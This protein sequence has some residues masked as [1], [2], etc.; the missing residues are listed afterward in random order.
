LAPTPG[1]GAGD[2][3][4]G[5][6]A[7]LRP[8]CRCGTELPGGRGG[9]RDFH[10]H[11]HEPAVLCPTE[12]AGVPGAARQAMKRVNAEML[13]AYLDGELDAVARARVEAWLADHPVAAAALEQRRR[14]NELWEATV[15]PVPVEARWTAVRARI[16][17]AMPARPMQRSNQRLVLGLVAGTAAAVLFLFVFPH[18]PA[19]ETSRRPEPAE[20][21][22]VAGP[23]DVEIVSLD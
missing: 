6:T 8:A 17:M 4:R 3:T 21:F 16:R 23:D 2:A 7:D 19:P 22:P 9:A 15:P 11:G 13:D 20:V 12:T 10:R 14:L 5:P 1:P 18:Q